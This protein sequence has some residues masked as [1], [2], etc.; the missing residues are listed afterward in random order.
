VQTWL[1]YLLPSLARCGWN[2]VLG[3]VSGRLHNVARYVEV[4]P[5]HDYIAIDSPTG[6]REGRI[7]ALVQAIR[8]VQ[9][10]LVVAVNV[11]D[12]Y[13]AVERMRFDGEP[14][15]HIAMADHSVEPDFL[16]DAASWR[17][18]LDAFI[19]TNQLTLR[20]ARDYSRLEHQRMYYAPYGVPVTTPPSGPQ[21][22]GTGPLRI[23]YAGR[24]DE[25]QKRAQDIAPILDRL[26]SLGVD[27]RL[28]IAG[29]GPYLTA[30]TEQLRGRVERGLVQMLGV[31]DSAS[32]D[33]QLYAWS[34]ILLVTSS[35][36][37]GPIVAWEAMARNVA[38]VSTQYVGSG[39]ED[40]LQSDENCL[41]FPV[42]DVHAAA[43]QLHRACDNALRGHLTRSGHALVRSRYSRERS[44]AAWDA[45]MRDVLARP[46]L[47][48]PVRVAGAAPSGR[49]DR[50]LGSSRGET[51]RRWMGRSYRH[52]E[53]GGE[54]PHADHGLSA[55]QQQEFWAMAQRADRS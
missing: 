18:V 38:L 46:R 13:A 30:L 50:W 6:A 24:V 54:W 9:P 40:A 31:L 20:L 35:W 26:E 2:P 14:A 19:G 21:E 25:N 29:G 28:R 41:L 44:I 23:A 48:A 22:G 17:H 45:C 32:L 1:D 33:E 39:L 55:A 10:Q 37:T 42:G 47:C 34:Q 53:P 7:R 15:P 11:C 12:C 16:Q 43:A 52:D 27:Y 8:R 5:G 36:E 3:L 51:L 49:L 4:H